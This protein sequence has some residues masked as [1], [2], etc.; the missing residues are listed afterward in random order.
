MKFKNIAISILI[1]LFLVSAAL[2]TASAQYIDTTGGSQIYVNQ[3]YDVAQPGNFLPQP[4]NFLPP[5]GLAP[6]ASADVVAANV[7]ANAGPGV[8][9]YGSPYAA[10]YAANAALPYA[11]FAQQPYTYADPYVGAPAPDAFAS[12]L[13]PMAVEAP[14]AAPLAVPCAAPLA[15]PFAAAP[16]APCGPFTA[17]FTYSAQQSSAFGP[18]TPPVTEAAEQF[19]QYPGLTPYG[20]YPGTGYAA[21]GGVGFDPL[22]GYYGPYGAFTPL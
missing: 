22:S 1:G 5:A 6:G 4:G 21:A 16:V 11:N 20:A 10:P 2:L 17:G 8:A 18:C 19:Y 7:A 14:C 3:P 15:V 9:A 12:P 13:G